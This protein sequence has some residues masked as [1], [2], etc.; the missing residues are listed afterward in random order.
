MLGLLHINAVTVPVL[1]TTISCSEKYDIH[2]L[3]RGQYGRKD[4]RQNQMLLL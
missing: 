4:W 3:E 1:V 2:F